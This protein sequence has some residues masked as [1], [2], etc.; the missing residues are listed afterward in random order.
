M[1]NHSRFGRRAIVCS[2]LLAYGWVQP[3]ASKLS[4]DECEDKSLAPP[5]SSANPTDQLAQRTGKNCKSKERI[6]VMSP[7]FNLMQFKIQWSSHQT[8]RI[9]GE[10]EAT[11]GS[12]IKQ[13]Q[14]MA[15]RDQLPA[16]VSLVMGIPK[17]SKHCTMAQQLQENWSQELLRLAKD[18]YQ[19]ADLSRSLV[20]LRAIPVAS[21]QYG[22]AAELQ[23]RWYEQSLI[24]KQAMSA[25]KTK[26]WQGVVN[27][28]QQLSGTPLYQT[29]AAQEL[30]QQAMLKQFEPD[31]TL[32][33]L[34][35]AET[36]HASAEP[37]PANPVFTSVPDISTVASLPV[38][39]P[40]PSA[41]VDLAQ[42]LEWAK[43]PMQSKTPMFA[44]VQKLK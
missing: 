32:M 5:A 38:E 39:N 17:N 9:S 21:S 8:D 27:R 7:I 44:K 35:T 42:A 19:Q 28:I 16:A 11:Y 14:E 31:E 22:Y 23:R 2:T 37:I 3:A 40:M 4:I 12:L 34:A 6:P 43:P 18:S 13:A 30:L 33:K 41:Q 29:L 15:N 26:N 25:R 1:M 36:G 20:L 10:M 24:L